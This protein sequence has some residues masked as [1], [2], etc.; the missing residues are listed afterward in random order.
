MT[1]ENERQL[2]ANIT[3]ISVQTAEKPTRLAGYK[4]RRAL[5]IDAYCSN[6]FNGVQA[7]ITA[8]STPKSAH[9][10]AVRM[11]QDVAVVAEVE[12]R[13]AA[14]RARFAV[15][16]E[17]IVERMALMAFADVRR[18]VTWD[19]EGRIT[20]VPSADLSDED[21]AAI[22]EVSQETRTIPQRSG[23]PIEVRTI[24]VKM[25]DPQRAL[26]QLARVLGIFNDKVKLQVVL[27][28]ERE[29]VR[30]EAQARGLDADAAVAEWERM[31]KDAG[32]PV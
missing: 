1:D 31:L 8:G 13:R 20:V 9:M 32:A 21:A 26:E 5:W 25:V 12:R 16:E 27:D 11:L 30:A 28:N 23:P 18:I 22:A 19:G 7:S 3:P 14:M 4:M 24:K 15:T 2:P 10:Y 29:K 17:R 6:G